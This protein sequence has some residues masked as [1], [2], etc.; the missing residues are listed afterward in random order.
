MELKELFGKLFRRRPPIRD[1]SELA[2][3]IDEHAAFVVQKGIYEYSRARAGHFSKVL[4]NEEDFVQAAERS[5]WRAYPLGLAMVGE[6]VE[7][8]LRPSGR[9]EQKVTS[10]SFK[11]LV[12][13]VFDRYPVP[14]RLG[15]DVWAAA[16]DELA[17]RLD[18]VGLHPPKRAM[19]VPEQFAES[20][21]ALMPIH[22][23]L[24]GSDHPT[25]KN[26]LK[27]T[28]CNVHAELTDRLDAEAIGE[29]LR[30]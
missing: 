13:S 16:R 18:L 17:R 28:L 22:G 20:Y 10:R 27:I 15:D 24:R 7:G 1:L 5:R 4:F 8:V 11:A 21:F 9:T 25:L 30:A 3:F 26:Y 14:A 23:S 2:D 12:L 6:I 29:Q 19:D